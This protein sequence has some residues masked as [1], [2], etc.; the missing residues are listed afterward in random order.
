[1]VF[2]LLVLLVAPGVGSGQ[3][4]ADAARAKQKTKLSQIKMVSFIGGSTTSLTLSWKR[5]KKAKKYEIDIATNYAMRSSGTRRI[6]ASSG[7]RMTY[8][9]SG[10]VTGKTYCF[11]VRA[12]KGKSYGKRSPRTCKPTVIARGSSTGT[13]Y[14]VMTYNVCA[15]ACADNSRAESWSKRSSLATSLIRSQDP[16]VLALQEH[17]HGVNGP[18]LTEKLNASYAATT[19]ESAKDLLY[20][21][22]RFSI[23]GGS[24]GTGSIE[25]SSGRWAVWAE[26]IDKEA[27]NRHVIFVSAHLTPGKSDATDS[28]RGRETTNLISAINRV[29]TRNV[30]VVYAGDFNSNKSRPN[31]APAKSFHVAGYYDAYDLARKLSRP[32]W[33]SAADFSAAPGKPRDSV[34]WGDHV[35]HVW[36]KPGT[37]WVTSWSSPAVMQGALYDS[38]M[39]S[40][41]KPLLV[42]VRLDPS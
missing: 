39:P 28:L 42:V 27:G 33:N 10:L 25:L 40:D 31:D 15:D 8:V 13:V 3:L 1:M 9:Y 7:T 22:S 34:K 11:Q 16:D 41:H 4:T 29:N 2:V 32:N 24:G 6:K 21:R 38:P 19:Y 26:L 18:L 36:V 37:S 23:A 14:R 30:P 5:V 17:P 35:D 12:K 20:K